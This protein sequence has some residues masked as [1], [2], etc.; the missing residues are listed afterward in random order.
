MTRHLRPLLTLLVALLLP[1]LAGAQAAGAASDVADRIEATAAWQAC[2]GQANEQRLACFDAWAGEQQKLIAAIEEK[3]HAAEASPARNEAPSAQAAAVR[4]EAAIALATTQPETSESTAPTGSAGIVGVGLEQGCHDRQF[5]ELSRF[6]ELESGSSCPTFSLRA[7]H[8][9]TISVVAGNRMNRQ[10]ISPNPINSATQP[11]DYGKREMRLALSVRTKLASGLLTPR[12]GTL[13]DS[14]WAA[15]TQQSYWQLFNGALSRPFR[16]TDHMP[17]L[18]YVYPTTLALPGG[19]LWRYS[20]LGL[21]HQSNGQSDPLSRSWNR[22]YVMAGFE[23]DQRLNLRL[24]LWHRLP[25]NRLKDNNPDIIRHVGRGDIQLD[26]NINAKNTL[27][28]TY[29][30]SFNKYGSGRLEWTRSLG[31]GWGNSF[32]GLHLYTA[33]F[34]GYGDS[35]LDYNFRRTVFSVGLSLADF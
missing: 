3:A 22:A 33:I 15:Y 21:A 7:F 25:E 26:W 35:L 30:G 28:A 5:S 18:I 29:T 16:N 12:G 23:K 13:R 31:D 4:A 2:L 20:G 32:S 6:W 11:I 10:P 8:P 1:G 27:R 17:E 34:H 9:S 24:R 14:L 19:W